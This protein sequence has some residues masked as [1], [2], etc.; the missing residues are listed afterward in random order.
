MDNNNWRDEDVTRTTTRPYCYKKP[1]PVAMIRLYTKTRH[2]KVDDKI[3]T[4]ESV[5]RNAETGISKG[6]GYVTM[7]SLDEAK[8]A[9]IALDGSVS[10]FGGDSLR[11]CYRKI[12]KFKA[13]IAD[14]SGTVSL[15]FFTPAADKIIS[16]SCKELVEKYKPANP[17][18]IPAEILAI[19]GK[20]SVFQL[21]YNTIGHITELTLDDIFNINTAGAGMKTSE[22]A[23]AGTAH[24]M[25]DKQQPKKKKENLPSE[26]VTKGTPTPSLATSVKKAQNQEEDD[27]TKDKTTKRQ[28]F[29]DHPAGFYTGKI[30]SIK[31][32]QNEEEVASTAIKSALTLHMALSILKFGKNLPHLSNQ[33]RMEEPAEP[34]SF[35][36]NTLAP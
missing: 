31:Q 8:A 7:S 3:G 16:R 19:E 35:L 13:Y 32:I 28:L 26:Q 9:I 30:E 12:Y 24:L 29:Q 2:N 25:T 34:H 10:D 15:T 11:A 6:R 18:K 20:T 21:H 17:K 4:K 1:P 36:T 22:A 33:E 14:A 23:L 27:R 5:P